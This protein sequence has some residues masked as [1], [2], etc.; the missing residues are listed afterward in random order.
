MAD[1]GCGYAVGNRGFSPWSNRLERS[2]F[3]KGR[4]GLILTEKAWDLAHVGFRAER[5]IQAVVPLE[6]PNPTVLSLI[7]WGMCY[8]SQIEHMEIV[9]ICIT[10]LGPESTGIP[11][12]HEECRE[13]PDIPGK[14]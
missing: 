2:I 8:S 7:G 10:S 3:L 1:S 4:D 14:C 5:G 12:L 9:R 11:S 6:C 13:R